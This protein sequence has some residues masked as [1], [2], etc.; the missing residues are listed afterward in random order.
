MIH[1]LRYEPQG[2]RQRFEAPEQQDR[3]IH[4]HLHLNLT[5]LARQERASHP[6]AIHLRRIF[7]AL[8]AA[9]VMPVGIFL[10][11]VATAGDGPPL[12]AWEN[13]VWVSSCL[14]VVAGLV[15][16]WWAVGSL[17]S[18]AWRAS[19]R[20][21]LGL[22]RPLWLLLLLPLLAAPLLLLL[23]AQPIIIALLLVWVTHE[24]RV[25]GENDPTQRK[26][27]FGLVAGVAL[28]L[29]GGL[30]WNLLFMQG[31]GN[32]QQIFIPAL[33]M[34]AVIVVI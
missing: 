15:L 29:L 10:F 4:L 8:L 28:V 2:Q 34:V 6:N 22:L 1:A 31:G 19:P 18:Q 11:A 21:R 20:G 27:G 32:T 5:F 17:L 23:L 12:A 14:L 33:P 24:A 16:A 7:A 26:L 25:L 30:V 9:T 13:V 3:H